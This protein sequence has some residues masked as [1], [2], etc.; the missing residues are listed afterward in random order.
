MKKIRI[1]IADDH[2]FL[3]MG[4]K[5]YMSGTPDLECVGEAENGEAAVEMVRRLKPDVVVMDLMMPGIDGAEA[6]RL[7]RDARPETRVVVLTSFGTTAELSRAVANGASGAVF[8]DADADRLT[9]AI[10]KSARGET[11][12]PPSAICEAD[13]DAGAQKL[14]ARQTEILDALTRG[15]S[16]A[17]IGDLFG[18]SGETVK[19]HL[20]SV[21]AKLGVA[22]RAEA[23]AI[24]LRERLV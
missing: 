4:L 6:T 19:K 7:I 21:F 10:R 24:A 11:L 9:D 8:K 20:S 17:E 1:L 13:W 2:A 15:L 23:V 14:S 22:N 18:I 5:S 16:N 12:P 3:R